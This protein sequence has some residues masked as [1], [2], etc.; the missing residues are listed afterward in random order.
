MWLETWLNKQFSRLNLFATL[1][2][3][4]C[5]LKRHLLA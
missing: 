1:I 2:Q 5:V 3:S 4:R